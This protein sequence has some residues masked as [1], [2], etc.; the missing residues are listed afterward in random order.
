MGLSCAAVLVLIILTG[1]LIVIEPVFG[2]RLPDSVFTLAAVVLVIAT[3]V[4]VL[5]LR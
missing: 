2:V 5:T 1:C 4:V 3:G